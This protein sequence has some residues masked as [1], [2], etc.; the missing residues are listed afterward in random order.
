MH[1]VYYMYVY[2][3]IIYTYLSPSLSMYIYI[4]CIFPCSGWCTSPWV[5]QVALERALA[6]NQAKSYFVPGISGRA[7]FLL[8]VIVIDYGHPIFLI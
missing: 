4:W 3:Y 1:M 8:M 7:F 5:K 2:I 6:E